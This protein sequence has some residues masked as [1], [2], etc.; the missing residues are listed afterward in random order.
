M[1][2]HMIEAYFHISTA[3]QRNEANGMD[4]DTAVYHDEERSSQGTPVHREIQCLNMAI[5]NK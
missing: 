5:R 3:H 1:I 4:D 2:R